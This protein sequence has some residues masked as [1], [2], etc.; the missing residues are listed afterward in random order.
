[1][2][3]Y[4]IIRK[5]KRNP[6]KGGKPATL[7]FYDIHEVYYRKNGQPY[8]WTKDPVDANSMESVADTV[9]ALIMMLRDIN[10]NPV[11]EIR[12]VGKKE[13]LFVRGAKR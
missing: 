5:T 9:D 1:M 7:H 11:L 12:K 8:M 4:R 13:K 6:T 10:K 3:N 2:W